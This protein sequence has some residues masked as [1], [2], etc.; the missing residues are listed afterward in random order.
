MLTLKA[1]EIKLISMPTFI[2]HYKFFL[3]MTWF[4]MCRFGPAQSRTKDIILH[5]ISNK[6]IFII[7]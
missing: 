6:L 3:L 7:L 4:S 1:M 2:I 5:L